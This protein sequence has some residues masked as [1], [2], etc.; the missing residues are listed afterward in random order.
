MIHA[1]TFRETSELGPRGYRKLI[2]HLDAAD[3]WA[4]HSP[5]CCYKNP[6][7]PPPGT[8]YIQGTSPVCPAGKK[9]FMAESQG[10]RV[11]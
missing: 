6:G 4:M 11:Q 2:S 7:A 5:Q 8:Q 1:F 9:D 10:L 3:D